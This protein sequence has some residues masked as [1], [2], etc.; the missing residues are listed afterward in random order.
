MVPLAKHQGLP[1]HELPFHLFLCTC[2]CKHTNTGMGRIAT[3]LVAWYSFVTAASN[4]RRSECQHA[5][6]VAPVSAASLVS[7]SSS[8]LSLLH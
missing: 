6:A 8:Q 7:G 3:S 5:E 1:S 4:A 2:L